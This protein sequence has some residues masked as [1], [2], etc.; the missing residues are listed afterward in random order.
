MSFH[1]ERSVHEACRPEETAEPEATRVSDAR[2][3]APVARSI[4]GHEPPS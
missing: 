4:F 2:D 3:E 1:A